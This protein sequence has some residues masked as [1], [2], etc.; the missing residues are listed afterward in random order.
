MKLRTLLFAVATVAMSGMVYGEPDVTKAPR[1]DWAS[2]RS[3]EP[4]GADRADEFQYG[5]AYL[6]VDRQIRQT[7]VGF[8]YARR[9]S[10][11]VVDRTGLEEA[12]RITATFDPSEDSMSFNFV[13]IL[14]DGEIIERLDEAEITLLRQEERLDSSLLDGD[15]TALIQLEDVRVGDIIDYSVSGTVESKLWPGEL[16]EILQVEYSVPLAQVYYDVS[17]PGDQDVTVRSMA[18]DLVPEVT[19]RGG[20]R[21]YRLHVFDPEPVR[22]QDYTPDDWTP[23]GMV[24]VSTMSSWADVVDWAMP[25]YD[26]DASM[27]P[28][29]VARLDKLAK[30]NPDPRERAIHALRLVQDDVRYLGIEIGMGSHV[31]RAPALTL[32]RGYGDCKDKSVLLVAALDHLGID[33]VPALASYSFG[34]VLPQMSPSINGFDHVIVEY[35]ID[36]TAYR[37]DPTM[38]HQGGLADNIAGLDYGYILPIR[39]GQEDL[40]ELHVPPV[41]EPLYEISETYEVLASDGVGLNIR[42]GYT[43]RH[44]SADNMRIRI[45]SQG[46]DDLARGFLDY[47]SANYPGA[48]ES[49]PFTISDDLDANVITLAATY[50]I[51]E[52][53]FADSDLDEV[54]PVFATAV[55]DVVPRQV[56]SDRDAP[57]QISGG[58][59]LRHVIR[60]TTPGRSF[61]LPD[62]TRRSLAGIDYSRQF[63][64][65]KDTLVLDFTLAVE[66]QVIP[67]ETINDVIRL[68]D[69]IVDETDLEIYLANA[70]PDEPTNLGL[71][72][73]VDAAT[74]KAILA[75]D[76]L[77]EEDEH[78]DAIV[79]I[80]TLLESF[81]DPSDVRGLLLLKKAMVLEDMDRDRAAI[82]PFTEAFELYSPPSSDPYFKFMNSLRV[83]GDT[84]RIVDVLAD[85][86]E[87]HPGAVDNLN[88]DWFSALA[89]DLADDDAAEPFEKLALA[90]TRATH[91][92]DVEDLHEY[93]WMIHSAIEA[94]ADDG[95][96]EEATEYL[97]LVKHPNYFGQLLTNRRSTGVWHAT[98]EVAS[99]DLTKAISNY[100]AYTMLQANLAPDDY[101]TLTS[102]LDALRLA[103]RYEEAAD[104]ADLYGG[105]WARVEAVG[106]DAY[107]F[108]NEAA[109]AKWDAGDTDGA[110]TLLDRLIGF[111]VRENGS[112]ISMA[113]NRAGLLVYAGRFAEALDAVADMESLG[114]GYASEYGLVWMYSAKACALH[115][116]G[117]S[118]EANTVLAEQIEPIADSNSDAHTRTLVCLGDYDGA[119]E[120]IKQRLGDPFYNGNLILA[121]SETAA[122]SGNLPDFQVEMRRRAAEVRNRRDVRD[123][124]DKVG[125]TIVINGPDA[126]W[127][128]F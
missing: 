71:E 84:R 85:M 45:A 55:Q 2:D 107:W 82:A 33:A 114:D 48:V 13:R 50:T 92:S 19:T 96:G 76:K 41:D 24:S 37:V 88:M 113:I 128:G 69:E 5:I 28:E 61:G 21:H 51:N 105:Q 60:I 49:E 103:G 43:Y 94:L 120:L 98:A 23:F 14:R 44:A 70:T 81:D 117:R 57:M 100:V 17:V 67:L 74:E 7:D 31:P 118:D 110:L 3:I 99:E 116:L 121:F 91:Q 9:L 68:G 79:Q 86:L 30:A 18:T 62:G 6:L 32:Q 1:P 104:F 25:L 106:E 90:I 36:G 34:N 12:A 53:T 83:E 124:F 102:H 15:I 66:E 11:E 89:S 109:Y 78:I 38:S 123:V 125:R 39:E 22:V 112:L 87:H 10:Y 122:D 46:R 95:N 80:N 4:F 73:E 52:K 63:R 58:T 101:P 29:F 27:P 72:S 54:L 64:H 97:Q 77:I 127:G 16:F 65:E 26:V 35:E 75:I 42:I 93:G 119:A 59:N 8:E 111:G 47:Y 126:Y 40:V 115:E 20:R 56:E 108:V